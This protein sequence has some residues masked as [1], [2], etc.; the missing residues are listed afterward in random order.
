[1]DFT[2]LKEKQSAMLSSILDLIKRF[3]VKLENWCYKINTCK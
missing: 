2:Y 1:M 3:I